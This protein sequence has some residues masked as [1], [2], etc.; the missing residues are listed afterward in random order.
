MRRKLVFFFLTAVLFIIFYKI[1]GFVYDRFVPYNPATNVLSLF[2]IVIII[3]P[4]AIFCAEKIIKMI[5]Q[6]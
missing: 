3:L 1:L 2:I 6:S 5:R 4:S